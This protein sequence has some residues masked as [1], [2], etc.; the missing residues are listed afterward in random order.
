MMLRV[1]TAAYDVEFLGS[2][3]TFEEKLSRWVRDAADRGA[4]LLLFPEYA[5][6]ELVSVFEPGIRASLERQLVELQSLLP[7]FINL[8]ARLAR[9]HGV[10]IA[11][12]SFPVAIEPGCYRN[13]VHVFGADGDTVY[14]DKIQMTRFEAEH[15]L[16]SGARDI[17][18]IATPAATIG[19]NVCYDIEFPRFSHEQVVQGADLILAPSCTDTRAGFERVRLGCRARALENQCFVVQSSLVGEAPWSP[20]I[21]VNVGAAGIYAP[22]DRGFPDDGILAQGEYNAPGW[23]IH[24]LDVTTLATVRT[25]GQVFNFRDWEGQEGVATH[26]VQLSREF[27]H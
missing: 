6:M 11:A 7:R 15:W 12:G 4:K 2:W 10:H 13:R 24:D 22:V 25:S 8:H 5:A 14:Q 27:N 23:V 18:I 3:S 26:C 17:K 16:I 21:D 9:E 20:A 1:A 19:I